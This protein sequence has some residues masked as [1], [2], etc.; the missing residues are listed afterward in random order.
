MRRNPGLS[1]LSLLPLLLAVVSSLHAGDTLR[2][3]FLGNSFTFYND[4]PH[5]FYELA[6]SAGKP[7]VTDENLVGGYTLTQHSQDSTSLAKIALGAFHYVVLQEQSQIPTIE[8]WRYNAMYPTARFLDSLIRSADESTAFYMTWGRKYGGVQVWG[9]E[10]SP[11]FRDYFEMQDS[12]RSSYAMVAQELS[13]TLIPAGM[14]WRLA[15]IQDSLADLWQSDNSHPTLRGSY[16]AACVFYAVLCRANPTGLPYTGGLTPEDA[17]LYQELAWQA[18][19]GVAEGA[20]SERLPSPSL[21]VSPNPFSHVACIASSLPDADIRILDVNG[22]TV[23]RRRC[24]GS[25]T[26]C[27]NGQDDLDRTLPAGVYLVC[28]SLGKRTA[29]QRLVF[30]P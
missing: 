14:A 3:L 11:P 12:L 17:L 15:R 7:V 6:L 1:R 28:A 18:V 29:T 25:T 13:A 24:S 2:V 4:L 16:L 8:Y 30:L 20:P 9:G 10:S 5:L 26:I 23:L 19:T 21:R 27:W 22:R